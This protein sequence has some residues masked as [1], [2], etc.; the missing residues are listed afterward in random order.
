MNLKTLLPLIVFLCV[1]AKGHSQESSMAFTNRIGHGSAAQPQVSFV[2]IVR[3]KSA[4][5]DSIVFSV[6]E[7]RKV[8]FLKVRGLVQKYY[9]RDPITLEFCG[10]Y[11]W[12]TEQDFLEFKNSDLAKSSKEAYQINGQARVELYNMIYPLK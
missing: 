2:Q 3:F 12:A 4:L 9:L 11:L 1:Y 10:I 5:P 6:I 7:K 8:A